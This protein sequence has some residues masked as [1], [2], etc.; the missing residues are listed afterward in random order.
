MDKQINEKWIDKWGPCRK[1]VEWFRN[2]KET[3]SIKVINAL[4]NENHMED[5][6]G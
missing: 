3:D 1:G 2:Q 6:K 4:I 5:A